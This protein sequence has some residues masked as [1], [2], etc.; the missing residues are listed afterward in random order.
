M[1]AALSFAI[2]PSHILLQYCLNTCALSSMCRHKTFRILRFITDICLT[3][4]VFI[5]D[6]LCH[7]RKHLT[8]AK[9][10]PTVFIKEVPF[11][12]KVNVHKNMY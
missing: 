1:D 9:L 4:L 7:L 10:L 8:S 12:L 2:I 11:F 6:I 5:L 3:C